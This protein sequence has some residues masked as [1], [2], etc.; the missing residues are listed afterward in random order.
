M[1]RL[2][3]LIA[4]GSPAAAQEWY[5][6]KRP[7]LLKGG[8]VETGMRS[9][10]SANNDGLLD[11]LRLEGIPTVRWSPLRRWEL[12]AELPLGYH[13]RED[14]ANFVIEKHRATG[15]G[16]LF[17]Q[18][19]FEAASGED[20]KLLTNLEGGFPTGKN[21]FKHR[22]PTGSGHY[23]AALGVT[24]MKV[25]DP[26]ILFTHWGYQHS[27]PRSFAGTGRVTPGRDFRFRFGGAI[28]LNP[29]ITTSMHVTGNAVSATKVNG[30]FSAGSSGT[31]SRLGWG[32]DWQTSSRL[33]LGLDVALGM[34]KNTQDATIALSTT[35][36]LF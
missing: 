2:L 16:D 7:V 9:Q 36:R 30:R 1:M 12:Y 19:S 21:Q 10:F 26:V 18:V 13:E 25:V 34:T 23:S 14:V 33:G 11:S 31:L 3:L 28:S 6:P 35:Y 29:R 32:L 20:W 27:F 4:L 24:A 8:S 17:T 22:V 15:V 5:I